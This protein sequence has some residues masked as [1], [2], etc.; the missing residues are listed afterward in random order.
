MD[1]VDF[2]MGVFMKKILFFSLYIFSLLLN[3]SVVFAQDPPVFP[4]EGLM[5][6]PIVLTESLTTRSRAPV[7][8][9]YSPFPASEYGGAVYKQAGFVARDKVMNDSMFVR[10]VARVASRVN[11]GVFDEGSWNDRSKE[12]GCVHQSVTEYGTSLATIRESM[13]KKMD[14]LSTIYQNGPKSAS[15]YSL[16]KDLNKNLKDANDKF[17]QQLSKISKEYGHDPAVYLNRFASLRDDLKRL[18]AQQE[19]IAGAQ[20]KF[21]SDKKAEELSQQNDKK[22][23]WFPDVLAMALTETSQGLRYA[24]VNH[25][26]LSTA[27]LVVALWFVAKTTKNLWCGRPG[28]PG[29]PRVRGHGGHRAIPPIPPG[30]QHKCA[31]KVFAAFSM[32]VIGGLC[33][34]SYL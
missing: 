24:R 26:V 22:G 2:L 15:D 11:G 1:K 21:V 10:F 18:E 9:W 34:L 7:K 6:D 31:A 5:Q 14:T 29:V 25:P 33:A 17:V 13:E 4:A 16:L 20:E 23:H 3:V 12:L 19:A 28:A 30:P 27:G 32:A 8:P